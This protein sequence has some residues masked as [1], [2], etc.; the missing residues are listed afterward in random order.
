MSAAHAL[1]SNQVAGVSLGGIAV[2]AAIGL[3]I[4]FLVTRIVLRVVV[5]VIAAALALGVYHQRSTVL[6][7]LDQHVKN[8]DATFLGIHVE[9]SNA[10]VRKACADLA[11]QTGPSGQP[12]S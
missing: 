11:K 4:A 7:D 9:A 10:T 1:Q 2:I 8:C 5:L 3:V 12:G 6:H